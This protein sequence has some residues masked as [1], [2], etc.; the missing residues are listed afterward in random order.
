MVDFLLLLE[1]G[2]WRVVEPRQLTTGCPDL[3]AGDV[4]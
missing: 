1:Q 4:M 2:A 3:L